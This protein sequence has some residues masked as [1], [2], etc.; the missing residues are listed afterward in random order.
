MLKVFLKQYL[1][2]YRGFVQFNVAALFAETAPSE[3]T[4]MKKTVI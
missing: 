1:L 4:S 2:C 3:A